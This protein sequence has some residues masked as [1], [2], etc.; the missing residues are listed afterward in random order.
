MAHYD[1]QSSVRLWG[2]ADDRDLPTLLSAA[3]ALAYPSLSEGFGLPILEAW[4]AGTPVLCS[5]VTSL[6]EV[7]GDAAL[8]ID[9]TRASA[10]ANGLAQMLRNKR[11]RHEL[12]VLGRE[13]LAYFSWQATAE[14]FIETIQR[15]A[16]T[17]VRYRAAA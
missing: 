17:Q 7:A 12:A 15:A 3:G 10:I 2:F 14:R 13:R 6:P 4:A 1:Q 8:Q 5:N 16:G 9:P 11:L